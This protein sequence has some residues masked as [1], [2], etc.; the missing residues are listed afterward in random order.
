MTSAMKHWL[1]SLLVWVI[2]PVMAADGN[3]VNREF[4]M[5]AAYLFHFAE[6]TEWPTLDIVTICL[7]GESP[8]RNFLPALEGQQIDGKAVHIMLDEAVNISQCKIL[9]LSNLSTLTGLLIE[10]AQRAHI[11]LVSDVDGFAAQG[12]M[13]QFTLRDNKLKL[14]INLS[15]VKSARLKLSSKLLRMAE[16]IE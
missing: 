6:L 3:G 13:V 16:I 1:L 11:L 14:V 8:L 5:K 4:Q 15:A 12:G 7:Q 2:N 10:Q 9:V